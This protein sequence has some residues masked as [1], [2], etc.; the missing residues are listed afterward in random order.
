VR[1]LHT[2]V[3]CSSVYNCQTVESAEVSNNQKVGKE[4]MVYK[5]TKILLSHKEK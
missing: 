5:D 1:Y 4:N 2:H 3:Y